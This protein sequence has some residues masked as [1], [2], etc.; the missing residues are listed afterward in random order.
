MGKQRHND[1]LLKA[2]GLRL[3]KL[4]EERGFSQELVLFKTGIDVSRI[5]AGKLNITVS[6]LTN[7]CEF[8]GITLEEFF[9]SLDYE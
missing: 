9:T 8:Y 6:T 7:L 5:E 3:R 2:I 1:K 4:R